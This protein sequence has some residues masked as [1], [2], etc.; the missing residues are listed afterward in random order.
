MSNATTS[1][2]YDPISIARGLRP[3]LA[4]Y[5]DQTERERRVPQ[6]VIDAI[7]ASGLF[8][9]MF[10]RRAGGPACSVITHMQT[11]AELAKACPGT[12]WAFGL[13]SGVTGTAAG[14]PPAMTEL[15]FRRGDERFCSATSLTGKARRVEGGYRI[16]GS[17]GYGS[18]CL[19]A[20]WGLNGIIIV[21]DSGTVIDKGLALIPLKDAAV[22][23]EDTWKVLGVLGSGSNTIVADE[24]FVPT[25]L[26]L[27]NS[28]APS[29]DMLLAMPG[30]EPRD[31]WPMEP[32][33]PLGVLAPMLG[34]AEAM[35]EL[36]SAT[37]PKRGVVGWRY[38]HQADSETLVGQLGEAAMEIDS[39]WLH[40]RRGAAGL[41]E[42]APLRELSGY[43]K[44][45]I[46]ADCGYAMALLRRAGERLMD[47]AGP[48]GFA[49]SNSLQR[50]WRDLSFG[51]RH[52][53]MNSRLSLELYGRAI[54]GQPSNID[55]LSDISR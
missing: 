5:A 18:G 48:S 38:H 2:I 35:L 26:V 41:D 50:F 19:H 53:A 47:V 36:V 25:P 30:L 34:A 27:P 14:F 17:W 29:R 21:D 7:S 42:I 15:L 33:F 43:D 8:R 12:A 3:L 46:Q 24:V 55:L 1:P 37:M 16:S 11:I 31:L 9:M 45:Q 44:A 51:S 40:I 28:Q 4:D 52:N 6:S 49:T 13:L 10:P 32:R 39:A 22:H 23:I 20:D 54:L